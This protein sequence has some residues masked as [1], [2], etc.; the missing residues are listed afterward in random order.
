MWQV[1]ASSQTDGNGCAADIETIT[2]TST[3]DGSEDVSDI[4]N[5]SDVENNSASMNCVDIE[6]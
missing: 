5:D 6:R 2:V 1:F 3:V 4:D